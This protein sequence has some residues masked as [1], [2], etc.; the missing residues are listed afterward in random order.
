MQ[1]TTAA[2]C[3]ATLWL[4]ACTGPQS[5]LDPAG[6]AAE[7]IAD[8][9]WGMAVA[10][11]LIWLGVVGL[12][13]Y[14]IRVA[15]E[16]AHDRG[17]ARRLIL[18]GGAFSVGVLT[19]LLL[20]AL[21]LLPRLVAEPPGDPLRVHVTGE[22]FWWRVTYLRDGPSGTDSV[23]LANELRLPLGRPVV[24]H[25]ETADVIHSFWLPSLA[26]KV[27]LLPG[28]TTRLVLEATRTGEFRGACAEFCGLSHAYMSFRAVVDDSA[29]FE[30]WLARQA[31]PAEPPASAAARR[32]AAAFVEH[33]CPACHAV[34]GTDADG[35]IGPDL[36][37]VG[38][39]ARIAAGRLRNG[40]AVFERIAGP[41]VR[42]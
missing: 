32:G 24:L 9:W 42:A 15:P 11:I 7:R 14:A 20:A 8:L 6:V 31:G 41:E 30:A 2:R 40:F 21:R 17:R 4:T 37:H 16:K 18:G 35:R 10:G 1:A 23:T 13:V 28:R 39:R 22:E 5:A 33:G 34:R 27:D 36:T 12:T 19:I 38:S 29:G 3:G 25:L 26:G